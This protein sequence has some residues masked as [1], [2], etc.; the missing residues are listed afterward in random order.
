MS[1][2]V[3]NIFGLPPRESLLLHSLHTATLTFIESTLKY[4]HMALDFRKSDI[5]HLKT[6]TCN[7]TT[8]SLF[9]SNV[10][11]IWHPFAGQTNCQ[12]GPSTIRLRYPAPG[13]ILAETGVEKMAGYPANRNRITGT[14]LTN[15]KSCMMYPIFPFPMTFDLDYKVMDYLIHSERYDLGYYYCT[16][17]QLVPI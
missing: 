7:H 13:T 2:D 4:S 3:D 10:F 14:S 8:L 1:G 11:T 9:T 12:K 15:S 5:F 16:G 17:F 6:T